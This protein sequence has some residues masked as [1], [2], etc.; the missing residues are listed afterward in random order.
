MTL[1]PEQLAVPAESCPL[2]LSSADELKLAQ[3]LMSFDSSHDEGI[4]TCT[5]FALG[6]LEGHEIRART[7]DLDGLPVLDATVGEGPVTVVLHAH[8]DVVPG[9]KEQFIPHVDHEFLW[10]RGAYDMKGATAA[11]FCVMADI[12]ALAE[13]LG[14]RVRLL[15]VPDEED[16]K[17]KDLRG[18][19]AAVQRGLVGD[20]VV[21]GE[22]TDLHV[23]IQAKGVLDVRIEVEGRGAHGA[24]PWLGVNAIERAMDVID[25][26]KLLP[27]AQES[28]RFYDRPSINLGR[29]SGGDRINQV[30]ERC[31]MD[32][33]IRFLPEQPVERVREELMTLAVPGCRVTEM[34]RRPPAKVDTKNPFLVR[35]RE[36]ARAHASDEVQLVGRDGTN[37]GTYFLQRGIPSVEFGPIGSGH[38]GPA[39]KVSIRSLRAY[40]LALLDFLHAVAADVDQL[41]GL[42]QPHG[43]DEDLREESRSLL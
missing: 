19:E 14:I 40:R 33:D 7:F 42:V 15:S 23:G 4:R 31:V 41:T 1:H 21:C 35:L 11:M 26:L 9:K 38:H 17:P 37:D 27:F 30:P 8:I 13:P 28:S 29:I 25:R 43:I 2:P 6:W 22:P 34:Y 10:G 32:V 12:A 16:D 36:A 24:T 20:F 3:R 18:T 5:D 39:E